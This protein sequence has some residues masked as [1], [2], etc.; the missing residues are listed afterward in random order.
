MNY[1]ISFATPQHDNAQIMLHNSSVG[2]GF[3]NS[4]MYKSSNLPQQFLDENFEIISQPRGYGYWLWKPYIILSIMNHLKDGDK[5]FYMDSS[6]IILQHLGNLLSSSEDII[7]FENKDS[8]PY[9]Q[10]WINRDWTKRDCFILMDCDE[11]KYWDGKQANASYQLYTKTERTLTFLNEM[12]NYA[13]NKNILTDIP[14][15]YGD[16]LSGFRDHRH[17]Q[18]ILSLMAIK[19]DIKLRPDPSRYQIVEDVKY[20]QLFDHCRG[21]F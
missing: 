10:V 8:N 3:D 11:S 4:I 12:Y 17:D 16:N 14:N 21:K 15:I 2:K 19:Y 1:L 18:S 13:K 5:L 20:E 7:L 9:D 6:N